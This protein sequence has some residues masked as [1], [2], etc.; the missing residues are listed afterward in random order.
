MTPL[1]IANIL[2]EGDEV[3][4]LAR[5]RHLVSVPAL[6]KRFDIE[7]SPAR[8]AS[9]DSFRRRVFS[10]GLAGLEEVV[11][12]LSDGPPPDEAI[13]EPSQC[14]YLPP[15]LSDGLL[16][17]FA[18]DAEG[19]RP[20]VRR[21][22]CRCLLGHDAPLPVPQDERDAEVAVEIAAIIGDDVQD[23][24]VEQAERVV[25]GYSILALWTFPSRELLSPG[26]GQFRLG[27]LGPTL[28]ARDAGFDPS[29]CR[30]S[31]RLNGEEVESARPRP[32]RMSFAQMVAFAS[33]G[34]PLRAGDVIASGPLARIPARGM[35]PIRDSDRLA[36]QVSELGTLSGAVVASKPWRAPVAGGASRA[37]AAGAG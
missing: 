29:R 8:F 10:L 31:V 21:G 36:F 16:L 25:A 4:A 24:D 18:V 34:L 13:L 35:R 19:A 11:D 33:D 14:R 9:V 7:S 17:E 1:H 3:V 15:T 26:W 32:W 30:V 12:V 37:C 6:E 27:Q 23:A 5:G 20:T 2:Y 22:S 28:L